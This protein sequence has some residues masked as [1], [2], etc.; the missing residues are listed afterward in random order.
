MSADSVARGIINREKDMKQRLS[1]GVADPS[2]FSNNGGPSIAEMMLIAGCGWI[3]G[4]N[5]RQAG[6]EQMRKRLAADEPLLLFHES[7]EHTIRTLPYLQHDEKNPEDL[8]CWVAGT[9]IATHRGA[10]PIEQLKLNDR[11]L[12]PLGECA[13]LRLYLSGTGAT[14]IVELSNGKKLQGTPIIKSTSAIK[15]LWLFR[16]FSLVMNFWSPQ[17]G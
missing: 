2:I 1:Y 6:W 12:T 7:C 17:N 16:N 15:G 14:N 5:A 3:R 11:I 9:L 8:D 13:I 10:I 4:D